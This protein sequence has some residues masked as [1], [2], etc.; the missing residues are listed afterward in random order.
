M[1]R[2][3]ICCSRAIAHRTGCWSPARRSNAFRDWAQAH[4]QR[5]QRLESI[6]DLRPEVR[7]T[8]ERAEQF[9]GLAALVAV[10]LAAVAVA[11]A[12]SR[13]L[14]RHLD[15][16]AMMRCL[17]APQRQMLSLFALQFMV[18]GIGA[19]VVG[20]LVALGGQQLLIV[21]LGGVVSA[22]LPA[23]GA[24]PAL[25]AMASGIALLFGFALPPLIAL[26]RVPPLRVLRRDLGLPR[27]GGWLAYALGAATIALL[28][29][30]QAQDAKTGL[31][32]IAGIAGLLG[33]AG[34][35]AWG[36]IVAAAR[37]CRSA[38]TAGAMGSRICAGGRW[39]RACRS[40]RSR[41][42]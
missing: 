12:A 13:Y 17:G 42:V 16:A 10:M 39:R 23:P 3:R 36:L 18:L 21:L 15:A 30:W 25:A 35:V 19:S 33:V 37:S 24:W 14:R 28:I 22:D 41:W 29:V 34:A 5:G 40:A 2:R 8:L 6:R 32:M 7:Q 27:A 9:L 26:S 38:A 31:I 4:L 1:S 20:C 11:L